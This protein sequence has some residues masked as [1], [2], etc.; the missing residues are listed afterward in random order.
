MPMGCISSLARAAERSGSCATRSR[1]AANKGLGSYPAVSLKEARSRAGADRG[2]HRKGDRPNRGA[3][4]GEE[5]R[6]TGSDFRRRLRGSSLP[7]LR[8]SRP[9]PRSAI[10]GSAISVRHILGRC[11]HARCMRSQPWTLQ[12]CFGRSGRRNR[13]SPGSLSAIR[14]VF[15]HAR[16]V[17]RDEHGII[18]QANPARWDDLKAIGIRA[19]GE[20]LP[21]QPS[22]APVWPG[23]SVHGR[24]AR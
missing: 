19:P 24:S 2:P 10:N 22:I 6:Q 17:L 8:V 16:I 14:R 11:S 4:G 18:I 7:T 12:L 3:S 13:R 23:G 1:R 20:A 15:E 21:G 5:G 9:M